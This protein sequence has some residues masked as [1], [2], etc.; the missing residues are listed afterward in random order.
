LLHVPFK[1]ITDYRAFTMTM[2]KRNLCLRVAR[3][4]LILEDY[5][6]KLEHRPGKNM[7]HVDALSRNPLL[8]RLIDEDDDGLTVRLRKAQAEDIK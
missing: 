5:N 6:Y 4:A 8:T 3:W 2:A 7:T 1:I